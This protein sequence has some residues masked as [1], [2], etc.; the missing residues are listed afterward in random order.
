VPSAIP[1]PALDVLFVLKAA[2]EGK[3]LQGEPPDYQDC[4]QSVRFRRTPP[5]LESYGWLYVL[6][7]VPAGYILYLVQREADTLQLSIFLVIFL[8]FLSLEAL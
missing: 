6:L 1:A 3:M 7:A 4:A 5:L 8:A 2:K